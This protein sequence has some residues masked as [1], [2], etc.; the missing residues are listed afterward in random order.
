MRRA[1]FALVLALAPAAALAQDRGD[2]LVELS[3][4]L[5]ELHALRQVCEGP[6]DMY[7]RTRMTRILDA[8]AANVALTDAMQDAFNLGY[9]ARRAYACGNVSERA[10]AAAALRG[11]RLAARLARGPVSMARP[12]DPR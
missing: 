4:T 5:G 3:R 12:Q 7:W 6:D 8:E 9:G 11:R 10:E 2:T 1:A